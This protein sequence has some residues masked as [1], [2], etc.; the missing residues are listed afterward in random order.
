M[1]IYTAEEFRHELAGIAEKQK[2]MDDTEKKDVMDECIFFLS[3]LPFVYSD[4]LDRKELW[5]RITSGISVSLA[6]CGGDLNVFVNGILDFIK[7]DPA[8]VA[9]LQSLSTFLSMCETR[10]EEWKQ[11]FLMTMGKKKFVLTVFARERWNLNKTP[12]KQNVEG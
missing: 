2:P 8:R 4:D 1:N 7:A 9:A 5:N 12:A 3:I 10:P 6:K 11:A